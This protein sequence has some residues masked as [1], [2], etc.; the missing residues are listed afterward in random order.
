MMS[1]IKILDHYKAEKSLY[2]AISSV[3]YHRAWL[4]RYV[5][6]KYEEVCDKI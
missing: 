4:F 2:V 3:N 5:Q 1:E 6:L